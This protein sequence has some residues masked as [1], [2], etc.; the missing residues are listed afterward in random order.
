MRDLS[1]S[2][3]PFHSS[4]QLECVAADVS[5]LRTNSKYID[6]LEGFNGHTDPIVIMV[7]MSMTRARSNECR[8]GQVSRILH[9]N[10]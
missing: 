10:Y 7:L 3:Q 5:G 4:L 9:Y 6:D 1:L 2:G 8:P